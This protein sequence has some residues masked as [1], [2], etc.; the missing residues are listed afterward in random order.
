M[1]QVLHQVKLLEK[2]MRA[3]RDV[4]IKNNLRLVISIA[5]KYHP[6]HADLLD[7]IQEG[8]LGLM[9]AAEKFD[10]RRGIKFSTYATWWIRQFIIR[11]SLSQS[12]MVR[13]PEQVAL[14]GTKISKVEEDLR[15][16]LNRE[17]SAE[18]ISEE[19][20]WPVEKYVNFPKSNYEITSLDLLNQAGESEI[21]YPAR[22]NPGTDQMKQVI[23][24]DFQIKKEEM[25][26]ALS[27]RQR[28]ILLLRYGTGQHESLSLEK[29]GKKYGLTRERIRQIEKEAIV[30][31][32]LCY[33]D[34]VRTNQATA[35][36][37]K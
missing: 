11:S 24:E 25:L 12:R 4:L 19:L 13:V 18:E 36:S 6:Y 27:G 3:Y 33:R 34:K 31:L 30:K 29:V 16:R 17:P 8:N 32:K 26:Q 37:F 7:A 2:K 10:Y 20:A 35:V 21:T 22:G 28:E 14:W 5:R 23:F 1:G 9:R 15:S